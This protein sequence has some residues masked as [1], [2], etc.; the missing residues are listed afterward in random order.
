M[1]RCLKCNAVL[2]QRSD[3]NNTHFSDRKFCNQSHANSYTQGAKNR[4]RK[5]GVQLD[6]T[7]S[8]KLIGQWLSR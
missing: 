2:R 1:K 8:Q 3:E 6:N 5:A 7:D 4:A